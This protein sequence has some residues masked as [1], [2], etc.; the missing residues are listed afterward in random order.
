MATIRNREIQV[1]QIAKQIVE[2]QSGQFSANTK[3]NLKEHCNKIVAESDEKI[4][5]RDDKMVGVEKR[6]NETKRKRDEKDRGEKKEK[7]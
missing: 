2:G 4:R 7:E 5:E 1:V 3:T 6:K